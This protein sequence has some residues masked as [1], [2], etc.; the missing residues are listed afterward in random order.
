MDQLEKRKQNIL[1]QDRHIKERIKFIKTNYIDFDKFNIL[2]M[3]VIDQQ[4]KILE[5]LKEYLIEKYSIEEQQEGKRYFPL[6]EEKISKEKFIERLKKNFPGLHEKDKK[7]FD[8]LIWIQSFD[9]KYPRLL[10]EFNKIRNDSYHNNSIEQE[11]KEFKYLTILQDD[12]EVMHLGD[13]CDDGA[14]VTLVE[15]SKFYFDN[16]HKKDFIVGPQILDRNT[17]FL[18]N[19][20]PSLRIKNTTYKNYAIRNSSF[21]SR[22]F[23]RF[24]DQKIDSIKNAFFDQ[25]FLNRILNFF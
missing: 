8:F 16:G 14:G 24:I 17:L 10:A 25:E 18:N 21:D 13:N 7:I 1:T 23:I 20:S 3:E 5:W 15:G 6:A 12:I 4:R 9:S 22:T 11:I 19:S 2:I